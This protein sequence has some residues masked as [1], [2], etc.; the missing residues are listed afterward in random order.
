MRFPFKK[1]R[2]DNEGRLKSGSCIPTMFR[3]AANPSKQIET[4]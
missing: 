3:R 2:S 1:Y 4:A